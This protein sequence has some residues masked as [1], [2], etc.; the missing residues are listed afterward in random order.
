MVAVL[1]QSPCSADKVKGLLLRIRGFLIFW[2]VASQ[3]CWM[4]NGDKTRL[5]QENKVISI[6]KTPKD[7][8]L[9]HFLLKMRCGPFL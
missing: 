9:F 3:S 6:K 2:G 7:Q 5:S 1:F 8:V 4:E